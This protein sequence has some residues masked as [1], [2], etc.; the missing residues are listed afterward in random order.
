MPCCGVFGMLCLVRNS[1]A[2]GVRVMIV[3]KSS[4]DPSLLVQDG[5]PFAKTTCFLAYTCVLFISLSPHESALPSLFTLD[6]G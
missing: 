5:F 1:F 6:A 2:V 3:M 4:T